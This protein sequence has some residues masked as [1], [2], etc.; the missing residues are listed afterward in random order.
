MSHTPTR[1]SGQFFV[2]CCVDASSGYATHLL[3]QR[4]PDGPSDRVVKQIVEPTTSEYKIKERR[5]AR[6]S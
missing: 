6:K 3:V 1:Q 4:L 5:K 2:C